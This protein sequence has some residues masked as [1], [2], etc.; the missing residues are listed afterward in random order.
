MKLVVAVAVPLVLIIAVMV[1]VVAS[2]VVCQIKRAKNIT[3][4]PSNIYADPLKGLEVNEAYETHVVMK[5]NV[6]LIPLIWNWN[7]KQ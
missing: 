6:W 1:T 7:T 5:S 2:T 3:E 4:K